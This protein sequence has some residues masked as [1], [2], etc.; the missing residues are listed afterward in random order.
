MIFVIFEIFL[1]DPPHFSGGGLNSAPML[2]PGEVVGTSGRYWHNQ[3]YEANKYFTQ[4][5]GI[6][7]WHDMNI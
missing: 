3:L 4:K 1:L 2:G 6:R 7:Y 5:V